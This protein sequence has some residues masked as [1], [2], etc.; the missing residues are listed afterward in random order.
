MNNAAA[1]QAII[2]TDPDAKPAVVEA[3]RPKTLSIETARAKG[4]E[5]LAE[6]TKISN[7]IARTSTIE[8]AATKA[9][10]ECQK[11]IDDLSTAI[12]LGEAE[13]QERD[14]ILLEL[15]GHQD[16]L[17]A[18][19]SGLSGLRSRQATAEQAVASAKRVYAQSIV[20][21]AR[22]RVETMQAD[23][24]EQFAKA[25]VA[26][27]ALLNLGA[28]LASLDENV[29]SPLD[30]NSFSTTDLSNLITQSAT[31][32]GLRRE[33]EHLSARESFVRIGYGATFNASEIVAM[34]EQ[35]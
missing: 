18:A 27:A 13:E 20:V 11:R 16:K 35:K 14:A 3:P 33:A 1:I 4:A 30:A 8:G 12:A 22:P 29:S 10:A 17:R 7:A 28:S 24:K 19:Q 2:D 25:F 15:Q 32:A 9:A 34:L 21:A 23:V 31:A 26:Q 6:L 5:A